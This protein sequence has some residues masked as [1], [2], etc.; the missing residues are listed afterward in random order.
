MNV[1]DRVVP[2][3]AVETLWVLA[4]GVMTVFAFEFIMRNMRTYFVDVAGKNADVIIASRLL[5]QLMSTRLDSKPASTGAMANN[6][7]EFESLR[8]F[9]TSGT[10]VALVD[11]PFIFL[12]IGV[13]YIVSGPVAVVPPFGL[14]RRWRRPGCFHRCRRRRLRRRRRRLRAVQH[15]VRRLRCTGPPKDLSHCLFS[16]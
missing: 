14:I 10:L 6:L 13:I 4:L 3:N 2:N 7:R 11:L 5:E 15:L 9:F 16:I 12:F 1:Y 8:E